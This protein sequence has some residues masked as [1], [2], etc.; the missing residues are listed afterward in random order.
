LGFIVKGKGKGKG[1]V[2]PVLFLTEH[3]AMKAFW[4]SGGT[5][6]RII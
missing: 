3:H 5:V 1:K 4:G 6:P 2:L